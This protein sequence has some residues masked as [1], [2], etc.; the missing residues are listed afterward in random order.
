M[1][2]EGRPVYMT[3]LAVGVTRRLRQAGASLHSSAADPPG[4]AVSD[5]DCLCLG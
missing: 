3:R 4:Q 2:T 1:G 5:R